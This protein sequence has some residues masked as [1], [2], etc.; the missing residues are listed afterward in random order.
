M[1][2]ILHELS[3]ARLCIQADD[4][5][6]ACKMMARASRALKLLVAA[7]DVLATLTP[8]EYATF[9]PHL[10]AGSGFQSYQHRMLE[11]LLGKKDRL[12][13]EPHRHRPEI[14]A[15]LETLLVEPS[16][17]DVTIGLLAAR[18]L[19]IAP[20]CLDR[21]WAQSYEEHDCVELAWQAVYRDADAHWDLYELGEKLVDLEDEFRQWRY[22]HFTTVARVIGMLR[23]TG[24]T[25]GVGYLKAVTETVLFPELW[26]VRTLL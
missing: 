7:W 26:S 3:S 4:L 17:Y 14:A 21:D 5:G 6:P 25:S 8:N 16:L 18:G 1:K 10:Q 20:E 12:H 2:L 15:A 24:G 9:R 22:R 23:G 11:F 19:T 13:L